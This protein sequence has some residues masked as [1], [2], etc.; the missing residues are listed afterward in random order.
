[1]L[2]EL[3]VRNLT[4][5]SEA[6]L[7][8]SPGLNV[9]V[10]ENGTGKTHLLKAAYSLLAVSAE[11]GRKYKE[12]PPTKT[13]L[14]TALAEKLT[15]VFRPEALG[16]LARRRRGRTRCDLALQFEDGACDI[17]CSFAT[18]SKTEVSVDKA[19]LRWEQSEPIYFPTRELLS[20]Y[21]DFVSVYERH[22]LEFEETWRDTCLLL[23]APLRKGP[24]EKST[25]DI[26]API[27]K[28]MGGSIVLESN[29]RF[30][31][32]KPEGNMEIHLVAEGHRKLAMIARLIAS[33]I[34]LQKNYLFWDEPESNL[35]PKL[36]KTIA[37]TILNLCQ[38]NIQIF[39]A[40]HDLFLLRELDLLFKEANR[41]NSRYFGLHDDGEKVLVL[42][43]ESIDDIGDIAS[44]D[45]TLD[46]SN[47]YLDS[48]SGD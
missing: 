2:K 36:T 38:L 19:P 7:H 22:Y 8:F 23:G 20:I 15:G 28:S 29:G 43:S 41:L 26:L 11:G 10:G 40:T 34:L 9:I 31:L 33:G 37:R 30:Y 46:Q 39:I 42:Q 1:M 13:T 3:R 32:K 14:Q 45:E 44:L 12:T 47:R 21:P 18:N 4:V 16:R 24:K 25:S 35:N 6:E 17:A 27:E 5:F 48:S